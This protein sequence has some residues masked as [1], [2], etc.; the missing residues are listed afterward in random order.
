[1][2]IARGNGEDG[3]EELLALPAGDL[4]VFGY[5]SLMWRPDFAFEE[6]RLARLHGYHRALCVWSWVHRG[7]A[8][9]PGLV[10]GLDLGGSCV[11]RAYRVRAGARAS[12]LAYLEARE[13][14][15]PVYRPHLGR[16]RTGGAA[17]GGLVFTVDRTH[18]QYAGKLAPAEAAAVVAGAV[19][20]SGANPDYIADMTAHL[21]QLGIVDAH[22]EAVH[23]LVQAGGGAGGQAIPRQRIMLSAAL[24][25]R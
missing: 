6:A 22:L 23:A 19:G 3:I 1:M 4:W 25:R 5:G 2:A 10:M 11:G 13:M 14:A 18:P 8:A 12:V 16:F 21:G 20:D 7:T 9:A 15:T 17:V 24:R